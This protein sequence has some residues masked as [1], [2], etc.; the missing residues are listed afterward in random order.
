[1]AILPGSMVC[2]YGLCAGYF[3]E[4]GVVTTISKKV[5]LWEISPFGK[6]SLVRQFVYNRFEEQYLDNAACM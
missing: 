3:E 2:D 1:M 5:C 6:T 4:L